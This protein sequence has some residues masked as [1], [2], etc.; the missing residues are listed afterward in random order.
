MTS[1]ACLYIFIIMH[2]KE[3]AV[4]IHQLQDTGA[5][6]GTSGLCSEDHKYCKGIQSKT[7]FI[8]HPISCI[9]EYL[10]ALRA[11]S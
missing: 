7:S 5:H 9:L 10:K 8:M 1:N 6:Y 2:S 3:K 4:K 11:L